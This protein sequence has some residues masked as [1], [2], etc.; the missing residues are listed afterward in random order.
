MAD[1][2]TNLPAKHNQ[3]RLSSRSAKIL[4]IV[5]L[6]LL[7]VMLLLL[8]LTSFNITSL[9]SMKDG[10]KS[11]FGKIVPGKGYPYQINSSAV[12][13][14]DVLNG[15]IFI[16]MDDKTMTLD[17]SAKEVKST[18]HTYASPAASINGSRAIVY[19]R[20]ERRYRVEN[21][22]DTVYSG[23]TDDDETIITA[24]IGK[25]GN[26]ALATLSDKAA[27]RLTVIGSS[28]KEKEF[29]W[30]CAD[31]TITSTA[32]S[33]NGKYVA[34]SAYGS[35]K[36]ESYSKV[37][38]FDFDYTDPVAEYEYPGTAII[39]VDFTNNNNVVAIGDNKMAFLKGLDQNIETDYGTS[40][41]I[42]F[43]YSDSGETVVVL[44][45]Y[46]SL[47]S[48]VMTVYAPTGNKS[49][50]KTFDTEVK[51]VNA[52]GSRIAV[53]TQDTVE[54]FNY[55]GKQY[56]SRYAGSSAISAFTIGGRTY[57]Y[58]PGAIVKAKKLSS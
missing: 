2:N 54:L 8:A 42:A 41:L 35:E 1:R 49:F 46:G 10:A 13:K 5:A 6:V 32:L 52:S 22:T 56:K 40:K 27:S 51:T 55:N 47:N 3:N 23:S 21:R 17:S 29:V 31:Y 16:L 19:N 30:N 36:G 26:I 9:A 25:K 45:D 14:V 43:D 33:D 44:A 38:V 12:E 28:Y 24:S 20:G 4:R 39:S 50:S 37:Y 48:Q 34:V 11:F 18:E 57:V 15:D 53:L 7:V 58:R